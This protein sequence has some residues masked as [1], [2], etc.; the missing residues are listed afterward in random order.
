MGNRD[1]CRFLPGVA[2]LGDRAAVGQGYLAGF[3]EGNRQRIV[4]ATGGGAAALAA[5]L[6]QRGGHDGA[7]LAPVNKGRAVQPRPM[8]A[9]ALT[10]RLKARCREAGVIP[11]CSPHDLRRTFVSELLDDGADIAAVQRLAG[12][13]SPTTTSRYDRRGERVKKKAAEMLVVPYQAPI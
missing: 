9:Q 12:H 7:L 10:Y 6:K 4:Y 13:Q 2:T 3:G 11:S 5:W 1:S 8:S